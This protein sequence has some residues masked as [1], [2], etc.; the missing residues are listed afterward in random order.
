MARFP[1]ILIS[2]RFHKLRGFAL[3]LNTPETLFNKIKGE[4]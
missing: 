2:A 1:T 4:M 3:T